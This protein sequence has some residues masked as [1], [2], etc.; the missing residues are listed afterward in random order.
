MGK[1]AQVLR[2]RAGVPRGTIAQVLG[3]RES[4]LPGVRRIYK[5]ILEKFDV[6]ATFASPS[7]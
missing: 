7:D 6:K 1:H 2:L 4:I 5:V 3:V